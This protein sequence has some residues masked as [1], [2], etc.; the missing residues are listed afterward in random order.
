MTARLAFVLAL[1]LTTMVSVA[2]MP[3]GGARAAGSVGDAARGQAYF[4][5]CIACHTIAAGAAARTGPNLHD[6]FDRPAGKSPGYRYS[7]QLAAATWRW[8]DARLDRWLT[9]PRAV[10]SDSSMILKT[11]DPQ[12]RRDL[13]A[14]L[15]KATR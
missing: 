9:D 13:I 4:N 5:R 10:V 14:Y 3:H 6:L 2:A 15:H 11:P 1:G 7:P 12:Q 8:D